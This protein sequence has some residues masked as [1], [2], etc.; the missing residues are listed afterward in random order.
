MDAGTKGGV[1][2]TP[3]TIVRD[4]KTG[5]HESIIVARAFASFVEIIERMLS[6]RSTDKPAS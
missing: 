6:G 5:E 1:N 2:G 4:N 3:T